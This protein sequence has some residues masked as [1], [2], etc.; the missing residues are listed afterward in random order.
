MVFRFVHNLLLRKPIYLIAAFATD[1]CARLKIH[2]DA[3]TKDN[4]VFSEHSIFHK[5]SFNLLGFC[6]SKCVSVYQICQN[7]EVSFVIN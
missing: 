3:M 7:S 4:Q 6:C 5:L 2:Y 1:E